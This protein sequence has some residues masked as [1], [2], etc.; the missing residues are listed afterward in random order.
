MYGGVV[1]RK[2]TKGGSDQRGKRSEE[3]AREEEQRLEGEARKRGIAAEIGSWVLEY[4]G[5]KR[6]AVGTGAAKMGSG[7]EAMRQ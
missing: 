7:G 2:E 3:E 4:G 5:D 6:E 1:E